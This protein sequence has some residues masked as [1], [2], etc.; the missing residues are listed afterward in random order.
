MRAQG[1]KRMRAKGGS[2][3]HAREIVRAQEGGG[4]NEGVLERGSE[5]RKAASVRPLAVAA[6]SAA[7]LGALAVGMAGPGGAASWAAGEWVASLLSAA[8]S[9][10][11]PPP[12][13]VAA[14]TA[15]LLLCFPGAVA[16]EF[17][18]GHVYGFP[19]AV[20]MIVAAK[21][22]SSA[23]IFAGMR[24][25]WPSMGKAR[26]GKEGADGDTAA[27]WGAVARGVQRDGW[28][29]VLLL[30]LGP[31]PSFVCSLALAATPVRV[32]DFAVGSALGVLP[33]ACLNAWQG[34][35][36]DTLLGVA[37]GPAAAGPW[38]LVKTVVPLVAMLGSVVALGRYAK[39]AVEREKA[40]GEPA[41]AAEES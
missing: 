4:P 23:G 36:L 39:D 31:F 7:A 13:F 3:M 38:V 25:I 5:G 28:R 29:F 21:L 33:W 6:C 16:F 8:T 10:Q 18:A 34:A 20:A 35:A 41:L 32:A 17:A 2:R 24:G 14:H 26:A 15:A 1:V 37:Q 30:R 12:A 40:A 19:T 9:R 22:A 27:L 11:I